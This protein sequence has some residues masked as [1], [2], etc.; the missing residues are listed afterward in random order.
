MTIWRDSAAV[1]GL[2][3]CNTSSISRSLIFS[4]PRLRRSCW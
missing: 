1:T 4:T 2:R 3:F